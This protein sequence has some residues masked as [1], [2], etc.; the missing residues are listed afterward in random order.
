MVTGQQLFEYLSN[1][2]P[3]Q[4]EHEFSV[5]Q[6]LQLGGTATIG[7]NTNIEIFPIQRIDISDSNTCNCQGI[8]EAGLP[9]L[10][11]GEPIECIEEDSQDL[12]YAWT[13]FHK[14]QL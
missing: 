6:V 11:I 7:V 14:E 5:V 10:V 3:K 1:L 9:V 8:I 13:A 2:S 4:R 12:K